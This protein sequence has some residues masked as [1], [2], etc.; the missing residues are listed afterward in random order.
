MNFGEQILSGKMSFETFTSIC[1]HFNEKEKKMSEIQNLKFHSSLSNF[2][3]E[4][5]PRGMH[6]FWE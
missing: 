3:V 4:T 6:D 2:V 5:L 1:S